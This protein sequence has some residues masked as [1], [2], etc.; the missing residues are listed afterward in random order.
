MMGVLKR[1]SCDTLD[2]F[3]VSIKAEFLTLAFN[4]HGRV[5]SGQQQDVPLPEEPTLYQPTH[6]STN[7]SVSERMDGW[8]NLRQVFFAN[9]WIF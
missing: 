1:K 5:H 3:P 4:I 9:I 6:V 8:M 2:E 7:Q